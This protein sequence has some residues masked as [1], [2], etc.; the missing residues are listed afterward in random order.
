[1]LIVIA[2]L[3]YEALYVRISDGDVL[4]RTARQIWRT[5]TNIKIKK[6]VMDITTAIC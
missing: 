1:M 2:K 3:L 6:I 4:T 5:L